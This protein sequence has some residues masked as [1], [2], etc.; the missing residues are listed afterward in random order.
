M[1]ILRWIFFIL[2]V[3]ILIGLF[4]FAYSTKVPKW[5]YFPFDF[6][7]GKY[8]WTIFILVVTMISQVLFIYSTGKIDLQRPKN[9]FIV[10]I[11]IATAAILLGFLT[12]AFIVS[13]IEFF[14]G[15]SSIGWLGDSKTFLIIPGI[16]WVVWGIVFYRRLKNSGRHEIFKILIST[17]IAGSLLEFLPAVFMHMVTS[18]RHNCFAG[19]YTGLGV[20]FGL[21]V[22]LWSFGP[23]IIFLF[24]REKFRAE[25]KKKSRNRKMKS[26]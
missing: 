23:G 3:L 26:V 11:P 24:M 20:S 25:L 22:M 9:K 16:L 15:D 18:R 2:Y 10:L 8:F 13:I 5:M 21:I 1:K 6:L 12:Y 7:T 17:L 4:G 19:I 14:K